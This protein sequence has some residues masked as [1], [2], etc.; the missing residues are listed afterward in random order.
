MSDELRECETLWYEQPAGVREEA[1]PLGSGRVGAIVNGSTET[2]H[3]W[4]NE[5]SVW[6]GGPQS[7][8]NPLAKDNLAKVQELLF[9]D[10]AKE[11][12]DLLSRTFTSM[13]PGKRH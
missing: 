4:M 10:K 6:H 1:L 13:P 5:D 3:L 2:E 8:V 11:A 9:A 7:R 12:E